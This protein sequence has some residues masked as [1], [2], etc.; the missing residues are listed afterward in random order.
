MPLLRGAPAPP[1]AGAPH[2]LYGDGSESLPPQS[3]SH[4]CPP[5][6]A[7]PLR[8]REPV[9]QGPQTPCPQLRYPDP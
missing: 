8:G 6:P 1:V 4:L 3:W 7:G 9:M 2:L 5:H